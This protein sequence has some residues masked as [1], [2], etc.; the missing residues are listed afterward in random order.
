MPQDLPGNQAS[1]DGS[2]SP[3]S[4]AD[5]KLLTQIRDDFRYCKSYW[6]ENYDEAEKDM[7]CMA[8]IPLPSISPMIAR[9]ALSSGRM[10]LRS[11]SNRPTT[12]FDRTNDRSRSARFPMVQ[13]I[14]TQSTG[15]P[16][17]EALSTL[18]KLSPFTRQ[19]L[20][21]VPP[22]QWASG[23]SIPASLGQK[24]EQE[25]RLRRIP[26]QFTCYPDPD[27]QES[28]FSD[29]ALY[30]VLDSMR[31]STFK[32]RYPKAKVRSFSPIDR[33]KATD[34]FQGENIVVAE[35]WTRE[36]HTTKDGE[37][38]YTVMQYITNGL[39]ILER[40]EWIGSWIPI[41]GIFG[42]ELYVRS[43]GESKRMFMSLIRRARPAQ[44][45]MA[46][47]AS[48]EAEEFQMAPRAPLMAIK[49][50]MDPDL[51]KNIHRVPQ[52]YIEY[53]IPDNWNPQ[54]GPPPPPYTRH[55]VHAERPSLR[56][57]LMSA[58]AQ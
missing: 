5:E 9:I 26:N 54:W 1:T 25:P 57:S 8:A 30:F 46:Y 10:R 21:P 34:W 33:E 37:K 41:I 36:E 45:M 17:F 4:E 35:Y 55:A 42:E 6:R 43:R 23:E 28:D 11:T 15:K 49:G 13:P 27:A 40:S 52:A 38:R 53:A 2:G 32:R 18:R 19:P 48:Q 20:R 24:G 51:H 22:Q 12:T 44:Q 7:Q 47:I 50:M 56:K 16:T 58:G 3:P 14:K 29:S 31:Q 39:E